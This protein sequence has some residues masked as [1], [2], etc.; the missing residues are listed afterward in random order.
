MMGLDQILCL[1]TFVFDVIA[2]AFITDSNIY[3]PAM[4]IQLNFATFA[5]VCQYIRY[6]MPGWFRKFFKIPQIVQE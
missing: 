3:G 6:S 1:M 2:S 4:Y 5:C